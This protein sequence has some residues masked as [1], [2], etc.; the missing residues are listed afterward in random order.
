MTNP[1]PTLILN[2]EKLKAFLLSPEKKQGWP[3]SLLLFNIVLEILTTII[4]QEKE[5]N[6]N[7]KGRSKT[8]FCRQH[9]TIYRKF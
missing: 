8:H 7:W 5:R 2:E 3:L 9:D 6:P 4:R 1:Q